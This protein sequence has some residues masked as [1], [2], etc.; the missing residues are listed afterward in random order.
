MFIGNPSRSPSLDFASVQF[1]ASLISRHADAAS[2]GESW[3]E[4][5]ARLQPVAVRSLAHLQC[6]RSSKY[7]KMST[8]KFAPLTILKSAHAKTKDFKSIRIS[9]CEKKEGGE[10]TFLRWQTVADIMKKHSELPAT[11]A[12]LYVAAETF[13][14]ARLRGLTRANR[15]TMLERQRTPNVRELPGGRHA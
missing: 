10:P 7:C 6:G 4:A 3:A 5:I 2:S 1:F 14:H 15:T 9:I 13:E 8:Y 12:S 11:A